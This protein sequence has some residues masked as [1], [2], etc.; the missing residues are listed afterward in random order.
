MMSS[1]PNISNVVTVSVSVIIISILVF[2]IIFNHHHLH[3]LLTVVWPV[4]V[5]IL[6]IQPYYSVDSHWLLAFFVI[7]SE[8]PTPTGPAVRAVVNQSE[9]AVKCDPKYRF[10]SLL[11]IIAF[12]MKNENNVALL[13]TYHQCNDNR[14]LCVCA[15][16]TSI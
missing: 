1:T 8:V 14:I 11:V 12:L 6:E 16:C 3:L 13:V 2:I 10:C 9:G 5:A 7:Q 15:H 4:Y